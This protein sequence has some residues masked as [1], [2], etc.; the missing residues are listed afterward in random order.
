[1]NKIIEWLLKQAEE[2]R[3][4]AD[5]AGP[6]S[7][8]GKIWLAQAGWNE[9]LA[10]KLLA[11]EYQEKFLE[12]VKEGG[13]GVCGFALA[14]IFGEEGRAQMEALG[15]SSQVAERAGFAAGLRARP[16]LRDWLIGQL[17]G[18]AGLPAIL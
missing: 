6:Q 15:G 9:T 7:T 4:K 13:D 2:A 3:K 11:D 14:V 5:A 12:A 8:V 17:F 18:S 16:I 1:M 10:A